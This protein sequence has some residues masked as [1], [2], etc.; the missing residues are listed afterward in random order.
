MRRMNIRHEGG[1]SV[2]SHPHNLFV[3]W[4]TSQD[5]TTTLSTQQCIATSRGDHRGASGVDTTG[6]K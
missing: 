3:C 2:Q 5:A 1:E 6:R 4:E